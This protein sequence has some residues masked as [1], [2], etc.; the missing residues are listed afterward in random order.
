[1]E[2]EHTKRESGSGR[3]TARQAKEE[4]TQNKNPRHTAQHQALLVKHKRSAPAQGRARVRVA[5]ALTW[6]KL[7]LCKRGAEQEQC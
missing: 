7:G 1:M 2:N 4:T 5:F 3:R 6:W